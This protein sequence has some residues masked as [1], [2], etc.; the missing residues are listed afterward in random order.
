[1][2]VA[3]NEKVDA[4]YCPTAVIQRCQNGAVRRPPDA[5]WRRQGKGS[6]AA[7][8]DYRAREITSFMISLV[9]P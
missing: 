6:G 7:I 8:G 5:A 4:V 2:L 9:P 3:V 1:M